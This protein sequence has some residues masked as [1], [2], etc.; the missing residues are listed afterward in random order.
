MADNSPPRK[1]RG[2]AFSTPKDPA[3]AAPAPVELDDV[4]GHVD[5]EEQKK[6]IAKAFKKAQK[7]KAK[8]WEKK[9]KDKE[10]AWAKQQKDAEKTCKIVRKEFTKSVTK[11]IRSVLDFLSATNAELYYQ[12]TRLLT[13]DGIY[14]DFILLLHEIITPLQAVLQG[15]R[16]RERAAES[17]KKWHDACW[18]GGNEKPNDVDTALQGLKQLA[19]SDAV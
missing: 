17:I 8:E 2:I 5:D 16:K 15:D 11:D 9:Q 6:L 14:D 1:A 7:E 18:D 19:L 10:K 4:L 13:L 3:D 12:C